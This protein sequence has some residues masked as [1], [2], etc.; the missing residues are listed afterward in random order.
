MV[1]DVHAADAAPHVI[2]LISA[3]VIIGP[4]IVVGLIVVIRRAEIKSAP[5][6][7]MAEMPAPAPVVT[8]AAIVE[9]A[10][11]HMHPRAASGTS[12]GTAASAAAATTAAGGR[13]D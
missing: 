10:A 2:I 11:S 7:A 1:M 8:A 12:Y 9:P 13:G 5:R 6:E 3:T 4:T